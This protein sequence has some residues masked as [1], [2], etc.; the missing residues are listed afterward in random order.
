MNVYDEMNNLC[1]AI[2]ESHEYKM[3]QDVKAKLKGDSSAEPLVKDFLKQK[4]EIELL[5][6]KAKN[7]QKNKSKRCRSCT[8]CC[9][10]IL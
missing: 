4:S 1:K 5:N 8:A 2:K 6:T 7:P 3:M 9:S 10:S